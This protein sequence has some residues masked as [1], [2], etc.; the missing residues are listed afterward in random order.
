MG[1]TPSSRSPGSDDSDGPGT[2][3]LGLKVWTGYTRFLTK[4]LARA[5]AEMS[6]QVFAYSLKKS[7]ESC[8]GHIDD[9]QRADCERL[10]VDIARKFSRLI[11]R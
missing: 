9:A 5:K 1:R 8:N 10:Q 2:A 6:P 7:S 11:A 4:T 3:H